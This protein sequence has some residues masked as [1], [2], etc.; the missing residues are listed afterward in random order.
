MT[1]VIFTYKKTFIII[2]CELKEKMKDICQKFKEKK[3]LY[4]LEL[5]YFYKEEKINEELTF[6]E[7]SDEIDKERKTLYINVEKTNKKNKKKDKEKDLNAYTNKI[8]HLFKKN[9]NLV[10]KYDIT[11]TNDNYG[12]NDIFEV[13]LCFKDNKEYIVSPNTNYNLDIFILCENKKVLSVEGHTKRI[14]TIRYFINNADNNEYLISADKK[15]TVI[16]WDVSNNFNIKFKIE[17]NYIK[18]IYS[19]LLI[20]N[21]NNEDK[22]V[23]DE[24]YGYIITSSNST[25]DN[26]LESATKIYSLNNGTFIRYIH[27]SNLNVIWYLLSWRNKKN[28]IYYIIELSARKIIINNLLEDNL[29]AELVHLPEHNHYSGFI[30]NEGE[31]DYLCV[32]SQNGFITIWNLYEKNYVRSINTYKCNL[33]HII[34]WNNKYVIV[35]DS[36]NKSFKIIDLT[37][38]K[39]ISEIKGQHTQNALSVKKIYNPTYGELLLSAS[40]DKTIK[41]WGL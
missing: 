27:N 7:L 2:E 33:L 12:L 6:E 35:A 4:N 26:T 32:S 16:V 10:Y 34:Q 30:Y 19:C 29:Y 41:L 15:K 8:N 14:S 21:D 38:Y 25:G 11:N 40:S 13:F 9:P 18:N 20:F 36:W 24:D 17:T 5:S 1:K 39:V 28:N 3:E 37:I 22:D 31:N 23:E